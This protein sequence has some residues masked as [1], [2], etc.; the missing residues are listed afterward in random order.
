MD[1][2]MQDALLSLKRDGNGCIICECANL[3]EIVGSLMFVTE[4]ILL[5]GIFARRFDLLAITTPG[6]KCAWALFSGKRGKRIGLVPLLRY[7][8]G[9][10]TKKLIFLC[11]WTSQTSQLFK[12][13]P[14][15]WLLVP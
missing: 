7:L 13:Y 6:K 3:Q 11:V 15:V 5:R 14:F 8:Y 12:K 1:S 2:T 4:S 9:L 10:F